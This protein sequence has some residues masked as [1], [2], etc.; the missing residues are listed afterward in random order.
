MRKIDS[1]KTRGDDEDRVSKELE[2]EKKETSFDQRNEQHERSMAVDASSD[3][4]KLLGKT[5]RA[6][7]GLVKSD[8]ELA[9]FSS[10]DR[11][12]IAHEVRNLKGDLETTTKKLEALFERFGSFMFDSLDRSTEAFVRTVFKIDYSGE[13]PGS[14]NFSREKCESNIV[15]FNEDL[16]RARKEGKEREVADLGLKIRLERI[17]KSVLDAR[18][19]AIKENI[20]NKATESF[21]NAS[22]EELC[23]AQAHCEAGIADTDRQIGSYSIDQRDTRRPM[24]SRKEKKQQIDFLNGQNEA[25][26]IRLEV[27]SD[28]ARKKAQTISPDEKRAGRQTRKEELEAIKK[29]KMKADRERR[30]EETGLTEIKLALGRKKRLKQEVE[31]E[32]DRILTRSGLIPSLSKMGRNVFGVTEGLGNVIFGNKFEISQTHEEYLGD[33]LKST[34]WSIDELEAAVRSKEKELQ[35]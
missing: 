9:E 15:A 12:E 4:V 14:I 25:E 35:H 28:L 11:Q 5:E 1:E 27:I 29:I 19:E 24:E 2:R 33:L 34:N 17:E 30:E 3:T 21:S 8:E 18:M 23:R 32:I 22:Y 31:D 7:E 6:V 16:E 20:R 10:K 13:G 26:K